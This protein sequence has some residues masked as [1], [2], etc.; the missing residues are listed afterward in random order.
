MG[1]SIQ[2]TIGE[3]FARHP[4]G[5][6]RSPFICVLLFN[7][8]H[9]DTNTYLSAHS[10]YGYNQ[11]IQGQIEVSATKGKGERE[12]WMAQEGIYISSEENDGED[13]SERDDADL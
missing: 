4:H 10:G 5:R 3:S 1:I 2:T 11:M 7:E 9:V 13:K 12:I 6:G 8:E